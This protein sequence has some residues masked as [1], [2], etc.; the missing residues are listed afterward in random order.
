MVSD[1]FPFEII[2]NCACLE[3]FLSL[4]N[5]DLLFCHFLSQ[6]SPRHRGA[7]FN[8]ALSLYQAGKNSESLV[9]L[10]TLIKVRLNFVY[11]QGFSLFWSHN[12]QMITP[13]SSSLF[14]ILSAPIM[15]NFPSLGS[16]GEVLWSEICM[17]ILWTWVWGRQQERSDGLENDRFILRIENWSFWLT[18]L[19]LE[20]M[21]SSYSWCVNWRLI[22]RPPVCVASTVWNQLF[23]VVSCRDV[24]GV[25]CT[26]LFS[27]CFLTKTVTLTKKRCCCSSIS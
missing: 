20:V 9:F 23:G 4:F 10:E 6:H 26:A 21:A 27:V 13:I 7:L 18:S 16:L 22:C 24:V 25:F 1:F 2:E 14:F 8:Y 5:F 11:K 19:G 15:E 12:V 3:D 17:Q